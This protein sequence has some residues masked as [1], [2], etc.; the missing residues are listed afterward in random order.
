MPA[1][2]G[3]AM[4]D[5][6]PEVRQLDADGPSLAAGVPHSPPGTLYVRSS[7]GGVVVTPTQHCTVVFG[8]DVAFVDVPMGVGDRYMS[9][10]HGRVHLADGRWVLTNQGKLPLQLPG[11]VHLLSGGSAPVDPGY[12]PILVKH[13]NG[14]LHVVETYVVPRPGQ[15]RTPVDTAATT[16]RDPYELDADERLALIV[17]AR[18]YLR[19]EAY[20]QPIGWT[21]AGE[22][23]ARVTGDPTWKG[24]RVEKLVGRVRKRLHEEHGVMGLT[25]D[26]VGEPVGNALNHN[27]ITELLLSATLV[28]PDLREI[29]VLEW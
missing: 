18:R 3:A 14:P 16:V 21:Q 15:R 6:Q 4:R 1:R 29:D 8:R 12:T 22:D 2:Q 13:R 24:K 17:L 19:H 28:P 11:P 5:K 25:R 9:R 26:E 23:M 7:A 10:E 27:L 20:A